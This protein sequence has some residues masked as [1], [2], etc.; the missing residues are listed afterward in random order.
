MV[1]KH[2]NIYSLSHNIENRGKQ[3]LLDSET[4]Q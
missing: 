2:F 3:I 4:L 1:S